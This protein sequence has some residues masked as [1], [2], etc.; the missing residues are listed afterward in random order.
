MNASGYNDKAK[1]AAALEL[2]RSFKSSKQKEMTGRPAPRGTTVKPPTRGNFQAP[3][4]TIARP[5]IPSQRYNGLGKFGAPLQFNQ[6]PLIGNASLDFLSRRDQATPAP[7]TTPQNAGRPSTGPVAVVPQPAPGSSNV[8]EA[9]GLDMSAKSHVFETRK[10]VGAAPTD[11]GSLM[12]H[13]FTLVD[14]AND[15]P[16]KPAQAKESLIDFGDGDLL[17]PE[18]SE[19]QC[20]AGSDL[21]GLDTYDQSSTLI[22]ALSTTPPR[23]DAGTADEK[24]TEGKTRL[25]PCASDFVPAEAVPSGG[26]VQ[27][28]GVIP[29][30]AWL[31]SMPMAGVPSIAYMVIVPLPGVAPFDGQQAFQAQPQMDPF[32]VRPSVD[33]QAREMRSG[34]RKPKGGLSTSKWAS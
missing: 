23:V 25:S 34:V 4:G 9:S 2:A 33:T 7:S 11:P 26:N 10:P 22:G 18:P 21:L 14:E 5:T 28:L 32:A 29:Q 8:Q 30:G 16:R 13:F 24:T 1:L 19:Q 15:S 17:T 12:D 27:T 20:S 3:R 6:P 31:N